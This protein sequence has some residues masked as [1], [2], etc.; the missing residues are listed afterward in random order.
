MLNVLIIDDELPAREELKALLSGAAGIEVIGECSN[1]IEGLSAIRR[2]RPDVVFLD[3]QMPR[4]SG[5]EILKDT[6]I[7]VGE[8]KVSY[9]P[10]IE[11]AIDALIGAQKEWELYFEGQNEA[12][13]GLVRVFQAWRW[14]PSPSK[15]GW[16]L[17]PA[18]SLYSFSPVARPVKF[19]TVAGAWLGK[20][21][22]TMSPR[23]VFRVA[24]ESD[25]TAF[26]SGGCCRAHPATPHLGGVRR[27][28][29]ESRAGPGRMGGRQL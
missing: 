16:P 21:L 3:I 9:T 11:D 4:L 19:A 18:S 2:L 29:L 24:L 22:I 25:M 27:G 12:A 28:C 10:L 26:R 17:R 15:Y 14:K 23:F 8:V 20:R 5:I 1:A 13:D 6:T 7:E